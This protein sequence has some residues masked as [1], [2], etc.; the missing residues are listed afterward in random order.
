MELYT[1]VVMLMQYMQTEQASML[2]LTV[3]LRQC[4]LDYLDTKYLHGHTNHFR[5]DLCYD[6]LEN[7]SPWEYHWH[8]LSKTSIC[9]AIEI[10]CWCCEVNFSNYYCCTCLAGYGR[11][12]DAIDEDTRSAYAWRQLG[13]CLWKCNELNGAYNAL[14]TAVRI[15]NCYVEALQDLGIAF[16]PAMLLTFTTCNQWAELSGCART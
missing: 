6:L 5:R 13:I 8:N 15:D 1:A 9:T 2:L 4:Y 12:R 14:K 10:R 11:Y 7:S 3:C 16:W